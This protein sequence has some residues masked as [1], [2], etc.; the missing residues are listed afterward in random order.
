MPWVYCR[1]CSRMRENI[2]TGA[3]LRPVTSDQTDIPS[4]ATRAASRKLST[5]TI[6]ASTRTSLRA[7]RKIRDNRSDTGFM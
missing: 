4:T 7:P 3:G 6:A 1:D 5:N 2:T